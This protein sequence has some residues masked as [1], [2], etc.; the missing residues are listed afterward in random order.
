MCCKV[1]MPLPGSTDWRFYDSVYTER[2]MR[3]PKENMEGYKGLGLQ[4][5]LAQQKKLFPFMEYQLH[6]ANRQSPFGDRSY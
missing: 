6:A 5:R 1:S 3:T 4:L 2:F